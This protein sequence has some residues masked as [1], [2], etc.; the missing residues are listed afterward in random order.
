M[1]RSRSVRVQ[2][3][4][5]SCG[6]GAAVAELA[7][8]EPARDRRREQRVAR[9]DRAHRFAQPV[10]GG[11]L[12]EEAGRARPAARCRTSWSSSWLVTTRMRAVLPAA[13]IRVVASMPSS[14]GICD[15]HQHDVGVAL[16]REL[17]ALGAVA[18]LARDLE[19]GLG[20]EQ[21]LH[22]A[23][24]EHVVVDE[25]DPCPSIAHAAGT[26]WTPPTAS[27]A[28]RSS[29]SVAGSAATRQQLLEPGGRD[30]REH[31][32]AARSP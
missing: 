32:R 15:V 6:A 14:T 11:V 1:S 12:E 3:R 7:L 17:D 29:G 27:S 22:A 16:E 5:L 10:G 2:K 28:A 25:D 18:G 8:D 21:R 4:G 20:V 13:T 23:A 24:H 9:G 31:A 19:V 30:Q 26:A